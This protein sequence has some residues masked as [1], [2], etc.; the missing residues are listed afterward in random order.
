MPVH[1]NCEILLLSDGLLKKTTC[2]EGNK[3]YLVRYG[4][5]CFEGQADRKGTKELYP[6]RV[7]WAVIS[8]NGKYLWAVRVLYGQ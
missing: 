8:K 1:L 7:V 3:T 2:S 5:R 4:Y 6:F